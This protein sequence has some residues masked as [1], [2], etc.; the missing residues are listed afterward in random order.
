MAK[1]FFLRI[2][3]NFFP[4]NKLGD[5]SSSFYPNRIKKLEE[6]YS[7]I[8][9]IPEEI[10]N[11]IFKKFKNHPR[12]EN[13]KNNNWNFQPLTK[14]GYTWKVGVLI[15]ING[16]ALTILFPEIKFNAHKGKTVLD[17]PIEIFSQPGT[18]TSIAREKIDKFIFTLE[19]K[20]FE[21]ISEDLQKNG[22]KTKVPK[23]FP[24]KCCIC[25]LIDSKEYQRIF[26]CSR[27]FEAHES[28]AKELFIKLKKMR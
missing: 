6:L 3:R 14:D 28:C 7:K 27:L 12:H 4:K 11:N 1:T 10:F 26:Y 18:Q 16:Y 5:L 22:L 17:R 19:Q 20:V 2:V 24:I 15:D 23:G 9:Y 25:G 8:G 13:Y 21:Y